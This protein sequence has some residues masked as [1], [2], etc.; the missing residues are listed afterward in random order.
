MLAPDVFSCVFQE[1][2]GF[3]RSKGFRK[4]GN[5]H[6]CEKF[7]NY[8]LVTLV[9]DWRS[10]RTRIKFTISFCVV[11]PKVRDFYWPERAGKLPTAQEA[12]WEEPVGYLM[13]NRTDEWWVVYDRDSCSKLSTEILAVMEDVVLPSIEH[14]CSD[15]NLYELYLAGGHS[16]LSDVR[17]CINTAILALFRR[18]LDVYDKS[19]QRILKCSEGEPW[20]L[21]ARDSL[22]SLSEMRARVVPS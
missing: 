20:E 3:L 1:A 12:S 2:S 10:T 17:C 11:C 9:K 6:F 15:D 22:K 13:P 5:W 19:I 4:K 16:S 8:G 14:F 21:F 18:D 7:G